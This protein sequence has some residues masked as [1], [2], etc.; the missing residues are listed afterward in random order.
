MPTNVAQNGSTPDAPFLASITL[1][2]AVV[3][4]TSAKM[5]AHS[6]PN[7]CFQKQKLSFIAD[8]YISAQ[9]QSSF[10]IQILVEDVQKLQEISRISSDDW[11]MTVSF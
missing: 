10:S 4:D 2:N 8:E 6:S 11:T 9:K 1:R 7:S 5:M 3:Y